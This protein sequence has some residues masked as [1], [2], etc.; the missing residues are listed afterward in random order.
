MSLPIYDK[1][2]ITE[3]S[4]LVELMMDKYQ[5]DIGRTQGSGFCVGGAVCD[6]FKDG[7]GWHTKNLDDDAD[8][9]S[10]DAVSRF[11]YVEELADRL[12]DI[13]KK[14]GWSS[15]FSQQEID[16]ACYYYASVIIEDND[17]GEYVNAWSTVEDFLM[18]FNID[19]AEYDV[20]GE[21]CGAEE[22]EP[23]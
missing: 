14:F 1:P 11:P 2:Q 8:Y 10:V 17:R 23:S 12:H 20:G 21:F 16:Q 6:Y 3:D 9:V 18:E 13:L 5:Y 4:S 22:N 15:K 7:M 19:D